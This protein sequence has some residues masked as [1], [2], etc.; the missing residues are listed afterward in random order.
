MDSVPEIVP[1]LAVIVTE[2]ALTAVSKPVLLTVAIVLSELCH[3]DCEVIVCVLLSAYVPTA[4][5][6]SLV[7]AE[8]EGLPETA[9]EDRGA[10]LTITDILP[11]TDS[12]VAVIAMVPAFKAVTRP[13]L[14]MVAI[15]A[16]EVCQVTCDVIVGLVLSL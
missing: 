5:N 11:D 8:S 12:R 10:W 14:L 4:V 16:S 15:V 13:E 1:M 2:P 6:C 3:V 7:L 9:I